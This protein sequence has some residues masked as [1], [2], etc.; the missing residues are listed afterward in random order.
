MSVFDRISESAENYI[1]SYVIEKLHQRRTRYRLLYRN[2]MEELKRSL[3]PGDVILIEGE[4]W[5]SDW[6]NGRKTVFTGKSLQSRS[7]LVVTSMTLPAPTF[8][9]TSSASPL[10]RAISGLPAAR[11]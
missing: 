11:W 7:A 5:V 9:S 4:H 8:C 3:R 2:D 1:R 10:A 6:I